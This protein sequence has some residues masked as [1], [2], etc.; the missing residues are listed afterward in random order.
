MRK[1]SWNY[2][3]F[4]FIFALT[5]AGCFFI[6]IE[7]YYYSTHHEISAK[8]IKER[9]E[10]L[11]IE[12]QKLKLSREIVYSPMEMRE[13]AREINRSNW[14]Q[15]ELNSK[16]RDKLNNIDRQISRVET[17]SFWLYEEWR[18]NVI[19]AKKYQTYSKVLLIF[20]LLII[21]IG[22]IYLLFKST[23]VKA[24]P[25]KQS[26]FSR[27]AHIT[28]FFFSRRNQKEIFEP[29]IADWQEE[30]FEA[31]SK[32]EIWKARWINVRYTYAFLGAMWQKT[33]FGDLIE[34]IS[35]IAK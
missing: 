32:N 34:F 27:F 16:Y 25:L 20:S 17:N 8:K 35:K 21:V 14:M 26:M 5:V 13:L 23:D 6:A 2:L 1:K 10:E 30:Y 4:L 11:R 15:G 19:M 31:L 7:F 9:R 28:N 29:I 3:F 22:I 33:P 18:D 12:K 24:F